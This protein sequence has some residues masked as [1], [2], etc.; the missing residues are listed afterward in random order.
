M[1]AEAQAK[2]GARKI[3][4]VDD[5]ASICWSFE[6]A[7][8]EE[9]HHAIVASTAEEGLKIASQENL[10]L[11]LLD[12]RL[13][14]EDGL[15][16][17]PKFLSLHANLP[18]IVMTAF[19]DLETAV[20]AV[21]RGAAD[22][23]TKP[24]NLEDVLE[25][26]RRLVGTNSETNQFIPALRQGSV[27][28]VLVGRSAAMQAVFREIAFVASSDLSVLI[29][30][31]TGTGKE[32]VAMAI[33]Q[34]SLRK[35]EVY[36]PIAPVTLNPDLI[37][38]ELFGHTKGSFTGATE[39][40]VGLFEKTEGGTLLLDEI[41]ELPL[42]VQA[43]MLRVL[44]HGE[45]FRVG[46]SRPRKSNVRIIAATNRDLRDA[47]RAGRFREDLYYRLN[48]M[49]IHLPPLRE[50]SDDIGFLCQH[51]LR[52]LQYPNYETAV[53]ASLLNA[54]KERP[55]Y[56]NVRE[57]RNAVE[58]AAVVARGRA[59][60]IEDFPASENLKVPEEG[61]DEIVLQQITEKVLKKLISNDFGDKGL[62]AALL[63]KIEPT[64][65]KFALMQSGGNRLK[66]AELLGIHR[67]TLRERL[68]LYGLEGE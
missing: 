18:V 43:K 14:K 29:T 23:I 50:R 27:P 17:L 55:W 65:L 9:G 66:A 30:G 68:R 13:P 16:A 5:E 20:T 62:Q 58:H 51:F 38:S 37:E 28:S 22:Y 3:L 63:E 56:G 7:F 6:R 12:V 1:S 33:H 45:F 19:G 60:C 52:L 8:K 26:C 41:G 57:L 34:H 10:S 46:E 15:S 2:K 39:D 25:K 54:L 67:S 59:L 64:L 49:H 48:G 24:F 44:E 36:T 42:S 21:G 35:D 40:K 4:I 47:V 11:L 32:L 53:G 61:N 31:E